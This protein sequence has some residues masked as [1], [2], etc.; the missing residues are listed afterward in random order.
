MTVIVNPIVNRGGDPKVD[1]NS[2]RTNDLL[3]AVIKRLDILI[4]HHELITGDEIT[5]D[6]VM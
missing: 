6:D 5:T 3:E 4:Q 2:D 1:V